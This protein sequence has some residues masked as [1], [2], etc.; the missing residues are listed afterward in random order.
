MPGAWP[1]RVVCD[2]FLVAGMVAGADS[3]KGVVLLRHGGMG[4]LL[5]GPRPSTLGWQPLPMVMWGVRIWR[6]AAPA[7]NCAWLPGERLT[8]CGG[9][10]AA[11]RSVTVNVGI[12]DR[13]LQAHRPA[14]GQ[15]GPQRRY[16]ICPGKAVGSRI[17]YGLH[18]CLVEDIGVQVDPET[19][20]AALTCQEGHCLA[21]RRGGAELADPIAVNHQ[22]VSRERLAAT[23]VPVGG[24]AAREHGHIIVADQRPP[25]LKVAH[26]VWAAAG[27]E[28]K[29]AC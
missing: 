20:R 22:Q 2:G 28:G 9:Q 24:V 18:E 1:A 13:Y 25:S 6:L 17:V 29:V 8:D 10:S 7:G 23:T 19:L 16:H 27:G 3:I 15:S 11:V 26:D 12:V 5:A 21:G 4:A 14:R